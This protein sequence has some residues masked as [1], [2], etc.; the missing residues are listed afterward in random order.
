MERLNINAAGVRQFM[1][2]SVV[3]EGLAR[4]IVKYRDTNGP[5]RKLEDLL[6]VEGFTGDILEL[7]RNQMVVGDPPSAPPESVAVLLKKKTATAVGDFSG[8]T[9]D[10]A[11]TR[12]APDTGAAVPFAA[13]GAAPANGE[14]TLAV[15]PRQS[16]LDTVSFRV[17]APD[18]TLLATRS[19]GGP[20]LPAKVTIEVDPKVFGTTQPNTD[21]AAGKPTR[22]RGQ[23]IDDSGKRTAAGLQVVI[24]GATKDNPQDADF[25]ALLVVTTDARGHFTGPYP[26]GEFSAAHATVG[27]DDDPVT[28]PVHLEGK[29]F[30]ESVI[31]VIDLPEVDEDEDDCGCGDGSEAPRSPDRADLA[32]ADGTFS[33]DGGAGRCVD[34]TKPD[35]TL[36]EYSFTYCVDHRARD[37][38]ADAGGATQGPG[39]HRRQVPARAAAGGGGG[40]RRPRP[41]LDPCEPRRPGRGGCAGQHR[42]HG[43]G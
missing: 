16:L 12:T 21:P 24:W 40:A 35:R 32:R 43:H 27:V 33:T 38:R 11:G 37:P 8:H 29:E 25:R 2:L 34:F 4:R 13:A 42:R 7:N 41:E 15:P 30:P 14:L 28:V 31:L 9:V 22:L 1:T 19:E 20:T 36:E 39:A 23:V 5:F 10:L 3:D 6:Q 26:V 17:L 18:G